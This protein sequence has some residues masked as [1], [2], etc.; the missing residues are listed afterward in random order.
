MLRVERTHDRE[1]YEH[2]RLH[3]DVRAAVD[4]DGSSAACRDHDRKRGTFDAGKPSRKDLAAD[5]DRAGRTRGEEAVG[6]A[7]NP[8]LVLTSVPFL[9]L[10][11]FPYCRF[12]VLIILPDYAVF[13]ATSF[14]RF[15][16][17]AVKDD[18]SGIDYLS[19]RAVDLTAE[20]IDNKFA[21]DRF[22]YRYQRR[23][24]LNAGAD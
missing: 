2:F 8:V 21:V 12:S 24:H 9:F 11:I 18:I 4:Q 6:D 3:V 5:Q 7:V 22:C 10:F 15:F 16:I 1:L 14:Y 23:H 13:I 19:A 20:M 17:V